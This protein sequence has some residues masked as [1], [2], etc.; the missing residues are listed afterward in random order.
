LQGGFGKF[1][2]IRLHEFPATEHEHPTIP[3]CPSISE[4]RSQLACRGTL[5]LVAQPGRAE[6]G[7]N[8]VAAV[9]F[10]GKPQNR[11]DGGFNG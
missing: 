7:G 6:N 10:K 2:L 5:A 3:P 1:N 9:C 4:A 11:I 8:P